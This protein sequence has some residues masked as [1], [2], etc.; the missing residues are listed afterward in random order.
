M[1]P[2]GDAGALAEKAILHLTHSALRRRRM[3]R[4]CSEYA[5]SHL[6]ME[7]H[8]EAILAVYAEVLGGTVLER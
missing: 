7:R 1:S 8:V 2:P 6:T 4:N 3:R 5:R